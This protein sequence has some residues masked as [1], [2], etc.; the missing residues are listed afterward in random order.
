M[1]DV[2]VMMDIQI[3]GALAPAAHIVVIFA[4]VH[5]RGWVEA[6][7]T[8]VHDRVNKPSVISISWGLAERRVAMEEGKEV[9]WDAHALHAI[10]DVLADA[11]RHG[12][13]V[14]CSAGDDGALSF[15]DD[16][17]AH[18]MFPATSPHVLACGGTSLFRKDGRRERETVWNQGPLK[19]MVGGATGGGVSDVFPLPAWQRH[20]DV[21]ASVNPD[22][23]VGR[24]IPDVAA[25]GDGRTGYKLRVGGRWLTGAAGTSASAPLWA[26][27]IARINQRLGRRVGYLNPLLYTNEK[28]RGALRPI[29]TGSNA[30][31][32]AA[33]GRLGYEARA[34]WNACTGWGTP[35]GEA[36]LHALTG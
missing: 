29:A 32:V 11:A 26:G 36:L 4:P 8:A 18:V 33:G 31:P 30:L 35:N 16:G 1:C 28:V 7:S 27:L 19:N 10:D 20:A 14:L 5:E 24:G 25:N 23:R 6:I 9:R 2:E 34:G 12:I 3:V 21:P 17:R 13:T 15:V 22:G